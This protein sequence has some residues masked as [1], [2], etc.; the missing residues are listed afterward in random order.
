MKTS[1]HEILKLYFERKKLTNPSYS[2]RALARDLNV[3]PA[4]VSNVL[5]GKKALPQ[6][7]LKDFI[8]QLDLD[9]IGILQLKNAL[10]PD[11]RID[12]S[13]HNH[14]TPEGI[15]FFNRFKP[16][17]KR[18]YDILNDWFN[19]AI[20]DLTTC[21]GFMNDP[22][23][24]A[25]KLKI[26]QLEVEIALENLKRHG[27][28]TEEE[29]V[30][31]KQES[32]LRF[33]TKMSQTVIRNFHKQMIKKAYDELN[34]KT[35]DNDFT[36]RLITG[37]TFALNQENIELLKEKIQQ[38]IYEVSSH[39]TEGNCQSVYQLNVQFFSLSK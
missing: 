15:D 20:L 28:L 8:Q 18:K 1:P 36:N 33:P 10:F 17:D 2:L 9:D 22:V 25:K 26:N 12:I 32:K 16:L 27:L 29:G 11:E 23:W 35:E 30:L 38:A 13:S 6:K 3:S 34:A 24:I 39:A 31:K 21:E 4:Y 37:A 14:F 7:R 5:Q 19:I